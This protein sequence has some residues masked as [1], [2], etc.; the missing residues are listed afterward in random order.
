MNK[1]LR[2]TALELAAAGL[3]ACVVAPVAPRPA[4]VYAPAPA[5]YAPPVV[6]GVAGCWRCGW[7]RW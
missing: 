6:V 4:Y 7:R 2:L 1:L 5:V 3:A